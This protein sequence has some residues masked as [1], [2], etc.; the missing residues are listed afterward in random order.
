MAVGETGNAVFFGLWGVLTLGSNPAGGTLGLLI[1]K[2]LG[3][4][5]T[6]QGDLALRGSDD[7]SA[8]VEGL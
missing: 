6:V 3:V 8:G 1:V 5:D 4:E 2:Q 7:F